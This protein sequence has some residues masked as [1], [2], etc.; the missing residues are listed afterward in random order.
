MMS[1]KSFASDNNSGVHKNIMNAILKCNSGHTI[2]YGED[3]YTESAIKKFKTVFGED[4]DIYF[5]YGGTGANVLG[6]TAATQTYNSIICA[7]TAHINVDECG[8]PEKFSGCKLL[9]IPTEDGKI[10]IG[11][12]KP[13]MHGF[14]F[15]HHSQPGVISITQPTEMGTLYTIDEIREIA[16]FAHHY[17][18]FLHMDG[19]RIS[20][21]AAA[22]NTGFREMTRDAGVDLLSFGGTKN[23]LMFGE[24][25]IFFHKNMSENFKYIRKQGMQ[26][27]SKMRY[28]AVQFEAFL[29][30]DLWLKNARHANSMAALLAMKLK[31]FDQIIL[32]QPVQT[33]AVFAVIPKNIIKPLQNEYFFYV[34]NENTNEVRWMTSYDTEEQDVDRFVMSIKHHLK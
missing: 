17:G 25:V 8:A 6:L 34:W 33:N 27:H 32:T 12:I 11:Q 4:A 22:M 28:I 2:G 3:P 18:L 21:A 9:S 1:E 5:V 26:L 31:G 29:S 13:H 10:R 30:E 20:N 24:A 7:E 16:E 19:A 15:P 14:G 23:G